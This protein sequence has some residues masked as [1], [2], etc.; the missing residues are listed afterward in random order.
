MPNI[1]ILSFAKDVA[2]DHIDEIITR[3][4]KFK[5]KR[6]KYSIAVERRNNDDNI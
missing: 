3:Y 5:K 4:F 1:G 2:G 6:K